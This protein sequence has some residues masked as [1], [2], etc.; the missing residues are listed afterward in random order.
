VI[1]RVHSDVTVEVQ[2][3]ATKF[4]TVHTDMIKESHT[5]KR[6]LWMRAAFQKLQLRQAEQQAAAQPQEASTQTDLPATRP[7][8]ITP[9]VP[10]VGVPAGEALPRPPVTPEDIPDFETPAPPVPEEDQG[11]TEGQ[12]EAVP[13][14]FTFEP[15]PNPRPH[16]PLTPQQA[17]GDAPPSPTEAGRG[18]PRPVPTPRKQRAPMDSRAINPPPQSQAPLS[19][20]LCDLDP[21]ALR[22]LLL[23]AGLVGPMT[24]QQQLPQLPCGPLPGLQPPLNGPML[25]SAAA[26]V[27]AIALLLS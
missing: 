26:R 2:L 22:Q 7:P 18:R 25:T 11:A 4:T 5:P 3:G 27:Q 12:G 6:P 9:T 24:H 15:E 16:S 19:Q 23:Q 20:A 14:R 21:S 1:T 8:L 17:A 13:P 10:E